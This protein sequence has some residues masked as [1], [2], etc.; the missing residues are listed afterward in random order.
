MCDYVSLQ[1]CTG[2]LHIRPLFSSRLIE[3]PVVD[4]FDMP[5]SYSLIGAIYNSS[6]ATCIV[7]MLGKY[8]VSATEERVMELYAIVATSGCLV[9]RITL[10]AL[11][12]LTQGRQ[13]DPATFYLSSVRCFA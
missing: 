1:Y 13:H 6:A 5:K 12:E 9:P 2:L 10:R 8:L 7:T 4:F 11:R 3:I